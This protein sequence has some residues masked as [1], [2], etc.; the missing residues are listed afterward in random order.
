[1]GVHF[2]IDGN[3]LWFA[4]HQH[5]P[6]PNVGRETLVRII[7]RWAKERGVR[8]TLFFD[9]P[10]P[11][12]DLA[13]QMSGAA[14]TVRFSGQRTADD[15]IVEALEQIGDPASV[16]VVSDDTAILHAARYRRCG[17]Q[18]ASRFVIELF[19]RAPAAPPRVGPTAEKPEV[20]PRPQADAWLRDF[21]YAPDADE[22]FP[23]AD[24]MRQ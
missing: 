15:L 24:A 18:E 4:M 19:P 14:V 20:V 7:D 6:V 12:G 5:A 11:R 21:G 16:C 8:A 23:G 17:V 10:T 9:G 1:M 3:N 2:L 22:T 13:R